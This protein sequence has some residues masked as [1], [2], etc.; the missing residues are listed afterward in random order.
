M[1]VTVIV[2]L[3]VVLVVAAGLVL[4]AAA[5]KGGGGRLGYP[6]VP[7]KSPLFTAGERAFLQALD[8]AVGSG[9]RVFGKVRIGD[10]A[11]VKPGL[12]SPARFAAQNRISQKHFDFVVCRAS[13]ISAVCVVELD[14]K[15]HATKKAR[16]ADEVKNNVCEVIGL[17][18]VRIRAQRSYAIDE[19]KQQLAPH[20]GRSRDDGL[21]T[22]AGAAHRRAVR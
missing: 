10:L 12:D 8:Q 1:S 14:D 20:I 17:P 16:D 22:G 11:E 2:V 21:R 18:L 4:A 6:Y 19:V 13:D 15:S 9:H 3:F 7:A 5:R